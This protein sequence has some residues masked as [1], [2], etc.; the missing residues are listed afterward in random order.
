MSVVYPCLVCRDL[1][2]EHT[3]GADGRTCKLCHCPMPQLHI[4]EDD[5]EHWLSSYL[6]R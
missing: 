1:G 2:H 3:S 5:V 4:V 6:H